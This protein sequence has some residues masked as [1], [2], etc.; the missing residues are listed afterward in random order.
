[1]TE[2]RAFTLQDILRAVSG[3][4]ETPV[5]VILILLM[6][7]AVFLLG[8]LLAEALGP[9]RRWRA[10]L[11][12]LLDAL[13]QS[14]GA[15]EMADCIQKSG[16]LGRQKQAL[17]ELLRHPDFTPLMRE[18]LAARLVD[19]EQAR[20]DRQ[21]KSSE[22]ITRL[23]PVFGLLGTLIP[24]GPGIIALGQ[25][26]TFTLS[27]SMMTA[28]DTTVAGLL[29]AALATV[30]TAVRRGWYRDYVGALETVADGLLESLKEETPC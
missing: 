11:P 5:V 13:R 9:R 29:A 8:W 3:A 17:L 12:R 7:A 18:S 25:G 24:L 26:D 19:R 6:A 28:F 2:E 10:D 21:L 14:G 22:L 16:L 1:M 30:I 27:Q 20:Y 4:M 23:G 15:E